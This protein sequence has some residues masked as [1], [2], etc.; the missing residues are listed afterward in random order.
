VDPDRLCRF[1]IP[2]STGPCQFTYDGMGNVVSDLTQGPLLARHFKYDASSRLLNVS[3]DDDVAEI[4]YGPAGRARI[5]ITGSNDREYWSFGDLIEEQRRGSDILVERRVP[6]PQGTLA[7]LRHRPGSDTIVSHHGDGRGNRIFTDANGLVVQDVAYSTFGK[8]TQIVGGSNPM[9]ST[10]DLWNGGDDIPELGIVL[11][12][13]RSYDPDIGRFLQRD[14]FVLA[15]R[16]SR[17]NP[18]AFAFSD[19]VNFSDPTGFEPAGTGLGDPDPAA[20]G[21][22]SAYTSVFRLALRHRDDGRATGGPRAVAHSSM[23]YYGGRFAAFALGRPDRHGDAFVEGAFDGFMS[24][25]Q[26]AAERTARNGLFAIAQSVMDIEGATEG[27]KGLFRITT[28]DHPGLALADA[29][30]TPSCGHGFGRS[31]GDTLILGGVPGPADDIGRAAAGPGRA[32]GNA[33]ADAGEIA[34]AAGA[35]DELITLYHGTTGNAASRIV[36]KGF[37]QRNTFFAEEHATA[38]HYGIVK[39]G[40]TGARSITVIAFRVPRMFVERMR[41]GVIGEYLD[42][43]FDDIANSSGYERVLSSRDV[44]AFNAAMADGTISFRR[45]KVLRDPWE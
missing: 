37:R 17:A 45:W 11:L 4:T 5:T 16:A 42:I 21:V 27:G 10:D 15:G 35:G 20:A 1:G 6:G 14:P 8:A 22:W 13:P 36:K 39:A 34:L 19:P 9:T 2:G 3:R 30:C 29:Y 28:A 41:R 31:V 33:A 38:A 25:I 12:G 18:Y 24:S 26:A 23:G 43:R 32:A 44:P 7:T 40:E